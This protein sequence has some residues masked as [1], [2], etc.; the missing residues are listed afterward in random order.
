ME[1]HS[2]SR[3]WPVVVSRL[4]KAGLSVVLRPSEAVERP[5]LDT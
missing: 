2:L 3:H 1:E 4:G 5:K